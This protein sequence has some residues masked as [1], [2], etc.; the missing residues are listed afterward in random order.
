MRKQLNFAMNWEENINVTMNWILVSPFV[1]EILSFI[2]NVDAE[3]GH[4]IK[5]QTN[6]PA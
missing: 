1:I 4:S 6:F 3:T 2:L 5:V